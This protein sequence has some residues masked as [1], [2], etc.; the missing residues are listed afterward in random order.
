MHMAKA[1]MTDA[2][3]VLLH[4][5]DWIKAKINIVGPSAVLSDYIKY[6]H[7]LEDDE[8]E[9]GDNNDSRFD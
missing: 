7:M 6:A 1:F 8:D 9:V 4:S 2:L 3:K 5:L